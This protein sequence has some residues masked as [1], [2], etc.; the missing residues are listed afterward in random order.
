[1]IYQMYS[2]SVCAIIYWDG[3]CICMAGK[4]IR[5]SV[6]ATDSRLRLCKSVFFSRMY[7]RTLINREN[8]V[9]YLVHKEE[10]M[11]IIFLSFFLSLF[12]IHPHIHSLFIYLYIYLSV[13][14][15]MIMS[16]ILLSLCQLFVSMCLSQ[17]TYLYRYINI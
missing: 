13:V 3:D 10:N 9:Q 4:C 7:K 15:Y 17:I 16:S 5:W 6:W 14:P 11:Y 12:H 2:L 8:F 1:M